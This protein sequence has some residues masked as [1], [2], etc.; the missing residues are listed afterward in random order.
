MPR[1]ALDLPPHQVPLRDT[2][3]RY[4]RVTRVLHWTMAA[5]ILWEF[6]GM[7]LRLLLG[8]HPVSSFFVGSHQAVG[9]V[10]LALIVL[11]VI[12]ALANLGRRPHHGAGLVATGAR[13][14]HGLLYLLMLAVPSL[15]VLR[16]YGSD[17]PWGPFG[18]E[19][20]PA[21]EAPVEWMVQAGSLLHGE[22]A[23]VMGA[24][25]VGH[26]IMVGIHEAMWRDG[27]LDRM[28]RRRRRQ[29]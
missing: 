12:W 21:R 6:T 28:I 26:V 8:R 4:G 25:I 18:F 24:L 19:I 22:L 23:W 15:A 11:R 29:A 2:A 5:L 14:G 20:F 13:I 27:T 3:A 1:P 17:R 10:L 16:A 7:G 9:T